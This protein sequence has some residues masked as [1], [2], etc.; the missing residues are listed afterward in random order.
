ME[1]A[2]AVRYAHTIMTEKRRILVVDDEPEHLL[3][4]QMIFEGPGEFEV[5]TAGD[6]AEAERVLARV[7]GKVDL[8]LLDIALPGETGLEFCRR[9]RERPG[10]GK[11]P[12]LAVSAYP[13]Y[14]WKEKALE[15]GCIDFVSKPFDPSRL[16]D[17]VRR[18][19]GS[20]VR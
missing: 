19:A 15:A 20:T 7:E 11:V 12:I 5:V 4:M 13:D 6:A 14:L 9:L 16:I 18:L 17:M 3:A 1:L 8:V 10:Y 2:G